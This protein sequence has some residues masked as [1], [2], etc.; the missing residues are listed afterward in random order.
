LIFSIKR[1][2]Y[3]LIIP[4]ALIL[5]SFFI[6]WKW[7]EIN[8]LF[9]SSKELKAFLTFFPLLPYIIFSIGIIMGWRYNNLGLILGALVLGIS[10]FISMRFYPGALN[11]WIYEAYIFLIPL[12][13]LICSILIRRHIFTSTGFFTVLFFLFQIASVALL[14]KQVDFSSDLVEY[15]DQFSPFASIKLDDFTSKLQSFLKSESIIGLKHMPTPAVITF[16]CAIALLSFRFLRSRDILLAGYIGCMAALFLSALAN[17]PEPASIVFHITAGLIL[18]V[19]NVEASFFMAFND[20][21]TGL[22]SRRSLNDTLLNLGKKYAIAM[23]DIDRFKRF[24][25]R[26]G[27][28]TGDD[29]L[30]IV[31]TRLKQISGKAKVF[32]YGGEEFTAVFPGKSAKE[33]F[34]HLESFRKSLESARIVVRERARKGKTAVNRGRGPKAQQKQVKVTI[35]IGVSEPGKANLTPEKVIK[36]ADKALY[37]AKRA[38]R[39]R[40]YLNA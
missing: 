17:Q 26:Y 27:H 38:G 1:I 12:N 35:S 10:Y 29:V 3:Q 5:F 8:N 15:I 16:S 21:L 22:P 37:K 19:T 34:S 20:E 25:D 6:I 7:P 39:N 4:V 36:A 11:N 31:A 30:K 28:K 24:N 18:I 9:K 14:C 2:C 33:S 32:R 13:L 23:M 40:T